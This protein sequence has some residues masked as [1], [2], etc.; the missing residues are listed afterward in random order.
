MYIYVF[1]YIYISIYTC[2]HIFIYIH[3]CIYVFCHCV[4]LMIIN[5]IFSDSS[6]NSLL[7]LS[8]HFLTLISYTLTSFLCANFPL[9]IYT[10][11]YIFAP[12]VEESVDDTAASYCN[13]I[14]IYIYNAQ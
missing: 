10:Y 13:N 2:I 12:E 14:Y 11:I 1:M 4:C 5:R 3:I 9:Y 8:M 6:M 7:V